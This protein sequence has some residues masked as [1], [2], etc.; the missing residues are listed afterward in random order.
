MTLWCIFK[1]KKVSLTNVWY[2]VALLEPSSVSKTCTE[3]SSHNRH[4]DQDTLFLKSNHR[5]R[6]CHFLIQYFCCT[7]LV[8]P[9]GSAVHK[10]INPD[11][12]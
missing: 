10:L 6:E 4:I 7:G 5:L 9:A 11:K 1:F 12:N 8:F 3:Q 2:F